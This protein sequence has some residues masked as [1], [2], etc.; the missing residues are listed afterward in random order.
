MIAGTQGYDR[1][2]EFFIESN[3]ALDFHEVCKDFI[4][5]L[6]DK[7]TKVLDIG[8]GA[9][10]NAAALAKLCYKVTAVEPM[11]QFLES[12]K[13]TYKEFNIKWLN[14]SLPEL[15]C[16]APDEPKF[17]FIL[18]DAIWHH[19][20]EMERESAAIRLSNI[21]DSGGKCAIS[22]RNGPAGMGTRV[23]PTHADEIINQF[24]N[25]GFKC[26]F[27]LHD[28]PSFYSHKKD[29]KWSRIVLVKG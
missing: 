18:I 8:S 20:N 29:V 23:F 12:A 28:Q 25:L 11:L 24:Q 16:L 17:D 2:I 14:G 19:L 1:F 6:P 4:T 15:T 26:V 13:S 21:I 7:F 22:L 27:Q 3:Q 5:F 9:G 10:Q